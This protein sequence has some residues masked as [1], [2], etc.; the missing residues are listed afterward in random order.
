MEV[1]GC[2]RKLRELGLRH[3]LKNSPFYGF[4]FGGNTHN[5]RG[6]VLDRY[7]RIFEAVAGQGADD[8]TAGRNAPG[9]QIAQRTRDGDS[10][11]RLAINAFSLGQQ[12]LRR[13]YFIVGAL[14]EPAF[15]ISLRVPCLVPGLWMADPY[16]GSDG[17][18]VVDHGTAQKRRGATC[19][20]ADHYRPS[21]GDAV[22]VVFAVSHPVRAD[23][24]GVPYRQEVIV[25]RRAEHIDDFE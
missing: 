25:G 13:E 18:R 20:I 5:R 1:A 3:P 14:V 23:V 11:G 16:G 6:V 4:G 17:L 2:E 12:T 24:A 19:L 21:C 22:G 7:I 15:G 10:G 8:P 9:T